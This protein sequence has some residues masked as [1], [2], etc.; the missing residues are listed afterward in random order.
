M[1]NV[2]IFS[3]DDAKVNFGIT[4][5]RGCELETVLPFIRDEIQVENLKHFY[6]DAKCYI[7]G[8]QERGDNLSI[9][10]IMAE[11]DLVLGYRNNLIVSA[12]SVLM[13][14]DNPSLAARL[15]SEHTEE[16]FRLMCFTDKP[17][18][19]EVPIVSQMLRYLEKDCRD[20]TKLNSEKCDNILQDYGSFETFV[21]LGLG[22]DF[23]FSFRHSE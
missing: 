13:K 7:W 1:A 19:G 16:P 14:T 8:V 3:V 9:W 21:R 17:H 6:P 12:L 10:N 18:L 23:P 5:E 2:F 4:I 11:G 20:F 22:Y 15:W